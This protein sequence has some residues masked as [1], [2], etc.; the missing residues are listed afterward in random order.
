MNDDKLKE[1]FH[2]HGI[3]V[4]NTHKK[5]YR[6]TRQSVDLFHYAR[7][8]NRVDINPFEPE[9][10]PLWTI[11]ITESE[12]KKIAEFESRVFNHMK[13]E[14]HYGLFEILMS[15]KEQE[16]QLRNKYPAVQK[17]YEQYSLMLNMAKGGEI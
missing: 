11:E 9:V 16:Q 4:L 14:G 13:Q 2:D 8:Y 3:R 15:Q 1:F 10:E 12:L 7:D 6:I 17:A 5:A